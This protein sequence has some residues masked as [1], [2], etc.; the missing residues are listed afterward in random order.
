[1]D[2][3]WKKAKAA[4]LAGCFLLRLYLSILSI[5]P[6]IYLLLLAFSLLEVMIAASFRDTDGCLIRWHG[7]FSHTLFSLFISLSRINLTLRTAAAAAAA[8]IIGP[9]G[10]KTGPLQRR[11]LLQPLLR[12]FLPDTFLLRTRIIT[13]TTLITYRSVLFWSQSPYFQ[14]RDVRYLICIRFRHW[15]RNADV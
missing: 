11:V 12:L 2:N 1:M 4:L 7:G 3:V 14:W 13:I 8:A 6:S 9:T 15:P 5:H 10:V